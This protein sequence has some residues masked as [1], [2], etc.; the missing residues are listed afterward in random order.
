MDQLG[1]DLR[2]ESL[3]NYRERAAGLAVGQFEI[4]WGLDGTM[5]GRLLGRLVREDLRQFEAEMARRGEMEESDHT[6][7]CLITSTFARISPS[8]ILINCRSRR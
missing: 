5:S 6:M 8:S 7:K 4:H 1:P 3:T 2:T